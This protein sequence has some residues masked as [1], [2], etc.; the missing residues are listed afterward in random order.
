VI[1]V[2]ATAVAVAKVQA[3]GPLAP[4]GTDLIT[5]ARGEQPADRTLFFEHEGHRALRTRRW[6]LVALRE[7]PWELYDFASVRSEQDDVAAQF[8]EVVADLAHR[9]DAWAKV[10]QVAP[11]P[12]DYRVPYLRKVEAVGSE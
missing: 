10:N 11:L 4:P 8:P 7:Q 3:T 5:L 9:W 12:R 2:M 1:D 6:K